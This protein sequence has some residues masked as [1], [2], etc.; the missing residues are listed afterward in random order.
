MRGMITRQRIRE[1]KQKL[2]SSEPGG[3][4][5]LIEELRG[6]FNVKERLFELSPNVGSCCGVFSSTG[7]LLRQVE[8]LEWALMAL[9]RGDRKNAANNLEWI[10][11]NS[12]LPDDDEEVKKL[13][14]ELGESPE[15]DGVDR[16]LKLEQ[17]LYEK[18]G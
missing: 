8:V 9:E 18:N 4:G 11:I 7:E 13:E 10:E 12:I 2:I 15:A 3:E 5:G 16:L 6:Y 14:A 1:L 17:L